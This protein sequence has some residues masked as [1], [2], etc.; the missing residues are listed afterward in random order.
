MTDPVHPDV[1]ARIRASGLRVMADIYCP[2]WR[3]ESHKG[4]RG[5]FIR[6]LRM[7]KQWF[8]PEKKHRVLYWMTRQK[9]VVCSPENY[10]V[11][12]KAMEETP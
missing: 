11:I 6:R 4:W 7:P 5:F 12:L 3:H 1:I 2:T 8:K 9:T 10:S